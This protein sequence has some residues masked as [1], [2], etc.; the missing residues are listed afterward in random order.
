MNVHGENVSDKDG[1]STGIERDSYEDKMAK[2]YKKMM[3]K[4]YDAANTHNKINMAAM[5]YMSSKYK[6]KYQ[7]YVDKMAGDPTYRD[8]MLKKLKGDMGY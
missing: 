5:H 2:D 7:G 6:G 8:T 1:Y 4:D 3:G